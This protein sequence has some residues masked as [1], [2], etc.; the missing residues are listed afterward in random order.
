M[1]LKNRLLAFVANGLMQLIVKSCR[2]NISGLDH[3]HQAIQNGSSIISFWHGSMFIVPAL[4]GPYAKQTNFVAC[5]SRSRDADVL[6]KV[7]HRY[8]PS[9]CIRIGHRSRATGLL[10]MIRE[11]E[12]GRCTLLVTPDGPKGPY[13]VMKEGMLEVSRKTGAPI[14]TLSWKS[15]SFLHL[16]TWDKFR[17]PRPF[18]RIDVIISHPA[19][20]DIAASLNASNS[21]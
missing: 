16:P 10:E 18:S 1:S 4:L 21:F 2:V 14:L 13:Q 17:I 3:F 15:S 8:P 9:T 19:T 11:V 20:E 7:I 12:K 6:E 5:I